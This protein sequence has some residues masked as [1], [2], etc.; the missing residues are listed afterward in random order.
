[1]NK[2]NTKRKMKI[3]DGMLEEVNR[4]EKEDKIVGE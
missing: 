4:E 2:K 1:M 3:K